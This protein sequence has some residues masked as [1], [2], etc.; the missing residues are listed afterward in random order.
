MNHDAIGESPAER[1]VTLSGDYDVRRARE[2]KQV[3][4]AGR[5][6]TPVSVDCAGVGF[7]DS[8][9][10]KALIEARIELI[11]RG[12]QLTLHSVPDSLRMLFEVTGLAA[13]YLDAD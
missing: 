13:S 11:E 9:G 10:L 5:G 6:S 2:L 7:M 1:V 4:I 12:S 8:T 3:L